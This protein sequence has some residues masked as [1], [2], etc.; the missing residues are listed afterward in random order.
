M[1]QLRQKAMTE[2]KRQGASI[3]EDERHIAEQSVDALTKRFVS[4][5]DEAFEAKE[6]DLES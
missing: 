4:Q 3:G 5:I 1:R 2:V 6:A